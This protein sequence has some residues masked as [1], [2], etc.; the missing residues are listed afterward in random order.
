MKT[1]HTAGPWKAQYIGE[2]IVINTEGVS[3]I[4]FINPFGDCNSG[5]PRHPDRENAC[6]ISAAP[7]LLE[8]LGTLLGTFPANCRDCADEIAQAEA[9]INKAKG[10]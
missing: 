5:I 10:E 4:A 8:A 1:K 6:I 7:D 2:T 9:A 3:G